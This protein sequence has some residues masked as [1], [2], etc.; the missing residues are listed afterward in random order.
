[1]VTRSQSFQILHLHL[2]SQT[3]HSLYDIPVNGIP[4][5][6]DDDDSRSRKQYAKQWSDHRPIHQGVIL[7]SLNKRPQKTIS[8]FL[9]C[10]ISC[11]RNMSTSDQPTKSGEAAEVVEV[12]SIDDA[13]QSPR[14]PG[15]TDKASDSEGGDPE[16]VNKRESIR[17]RL[18][19]SEMRLTSLVR[20]TSGDGENSFISQMRSVQ[21]KMQ[22]VEKEKSALENELA[23]LQNAT[24]GDDFLK[25]KMTSIQDGFMKQ[26]KLIQKL[27]DE[28]LAKNN[29][30]DHLRHELVDKLRRIVELEFDLETH[31]VHY[32]DYASEQ[33][34][35]GEEALA[36]IQGMQKEESGD[37]MGDNSDQAK[38][39][40]P[41]RAQ[42]LISKLLADLDDLES[43]YKEEKLE[44][45]ANVG[46]MELETE[47]LKTRV[48]VL[49]SRLGEADHF[50]EDIS[51]SSTSSADK[52]DVTYLRK[53]VET[54]EAKRALF[55]GELRKLHGE[56]ANTKK[57]SRE[58][59]KKAES[60]V[61]RLFLENEAMKS[62]IKVLETDIMEG[63]QSSAQYAE[64]EQ[65]IDEKFRVIKKLETE[66]D[67]KDRQIEALKK[68][69]TNR[70]IKN[71]A[72]NNAGAKGDSRFSELDADLL[73]NDIAEQQASSMV[74]GANAAYVQEL[75]KQLQSAQQQLVKK[76]QE[77]VIERAKAASTAAGLL[78]RITELTARQQVSAASSDASPNDK[79]LNKDST[80]DSGKKKRNPLRFYL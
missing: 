18:R 77:L 54:L 39:L 62:R 72:S 7:H 45:A 37:I 1:M 70:R 32:T 60:E 13:D 30:I 58:A 65:K 12:V 55:R 50:S 44:N 27:E 15:S 71:I 64:I 74:T 38:K 14:G 78:A 6:I 43:R 41:R 76:D 11:E 5:M 21:Q 33:F 80:K 26:V 49:M 3:P 34:K 68:D 19:Q 17:A 8:H 48:H 20:T 40:P 35:L 69:V 75:Q 53:R 56:V 52:M 23:K 2:D 66:L 67:I 10:S 51:E 22:E 4:M 63:D 42:K 57:Q 73:K 16:P 25:E 31:S 59:V 28:V 47:E 36:E 24:D 61:D 46:K 9:R 29:E 79:A